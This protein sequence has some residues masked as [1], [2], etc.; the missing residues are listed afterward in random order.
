MIK[1]SIVSFLQRIS[2]VVLIGRNRTRIV[3]GTDRKDTATS[4]YGDGSSN[5]V[6]SGTIDIVAGYKPDT[7]DVSL[8]DDFSRIYVSGK[9][10]P[11]DYFSISA[12]ESTSGEPAIIL[13]SDNIYIK[14][15][16]KIKILNDKFSM[17]ID[18][19]GN[20]EVKSDGNIKI[21]SDNII[22]GDETTAKEP[23]WSE[24]IQ[25]ELIKIQT[26]LNSLSVVGAATGTF[27]N[28]YIA[29]T[30]PNDLGANKTKIS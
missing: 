25:Q 11:D 16:K 30:S 13:F 3:L 19:N 2:D 14:S 20:I 23:A 28:P 24:K 17:I 10:D 8:S 26:T 29:P 6:D 18:Q 1:D 15:R 5:D 9:T 7:G 12:G 22:V 27:T 21:L 4:G